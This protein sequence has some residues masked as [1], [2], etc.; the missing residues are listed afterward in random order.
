MESSCLASA[1]SISLSICLSPPAS[2]IQRLVVGHVYYIILHMQFLALH[3]VV[4][5]LLRRYLIVPVRSS[6]AQHHPDAQPDWIEILKT[7]LH[8]SSS[9]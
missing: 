9:S 7:T 3:L 6:V 5:P 1:I 2:T 8:P 4:L